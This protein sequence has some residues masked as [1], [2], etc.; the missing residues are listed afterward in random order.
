M[1]LSVYNGQ[2]AD[3]NGNG[4]LDLIDIVDETSFDADNDGIPDEC[5]PTCPADSNGDGMV[6]I[7]E[8]LGVLGMW[9]ACPPLPAPCPYDLT[10][11]AEVGTYDFLTVIGFWGTCP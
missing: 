3:C 8:F 1:F 4:I 2:R 5:Q 7:T 10:G 11:D 9:G 6:G